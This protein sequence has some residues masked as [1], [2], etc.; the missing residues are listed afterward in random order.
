MVH[1]LSLF[2][3]A[4]SL[5]FFSLSVPLVSFLF[6]QSIQ[7]AYS[8]YILST[9]ERNLSGFLT[10]MLP[11]DEFQEAQYWKNIRAE[12]IFGQFSFKLIP[13]FP[14][15]FPLNMFRFGFILYSES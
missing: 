14:F 4:F 6:Q 15:L 8:L 13:S 12:K 7:V 2:L 10:G 11:F 3:F 5:S 1:I 9:M